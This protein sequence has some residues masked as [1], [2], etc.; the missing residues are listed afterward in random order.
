MRVLLLALV[1]ANALYFSWSEGYLRVFDL[2]PANPREPQRLAQQ[3][4]PEAMHPLSPAEVK[5]VEAQVAAD[6][7][8]RECLQA[9]SFTEAQS[10]PL[11]S[12]LESALGQQGWQLE[13][14]PLAARWIVYIGKLANPEALA[15]KRAELLAL[16]LK[17]QALQNP[18]LEIGVSL[19]AFESQGAAT[20][21]LA[22][23]NQ[24]GVRSAHVVQERAASTEYLLR[25]PAVAPDMKARLDTLQS[26]L[27]GHALAPC[28]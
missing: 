25:L 10:V 22:R 15:K 6:L 28:P 17:P 4:H 27:A 24:R 16:N 5:R 19:G 18:G 11:R 9:G 7:A 23:L 20:A 26:A 13:A 12:A 3:L 14:V 8:P 1:L 21:E 2:G